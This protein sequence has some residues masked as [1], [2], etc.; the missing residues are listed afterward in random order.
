MKVRNNI[1]GVVFNMRDKLDSKKCE[2]INFRTKKIPRGQTY[3]RPK[4]IIKSIIELI[5]INGSRCRYV[6]LFEKS[7]AEYFKVNSAIAFPYARTAFYFL[8]KAYNFQPNS[9]VIIT[10]ITTDEILNVILLN[11]LKPVFVDIGYDTGNIKISEIEKNITTQTRA[12][13]VTH[14]NGIPSEM[15]SILKIKKKYDLVV[16][17]DAS[18]SIGAKY[19]NNYLGSFVD[20]GVF[21]TS[22]HKPLCTFTGG[23]V[24]TGDKRLS[25][26]LKNYAYNLD[27]GNI[28]SLIFSTIKELL[29][30]IFSNKFIFSYFTYNLIKI[31]NVL[32]PEVIDRLQHL[33]FSKPKRWE[34]MPKKFL[35]S[36]TSYQATIGIKAFKTFEE[37]T[38]KRSYLGYLL[39][40][41]LKKK[42][43]PGLVKIPF[44]SFCSFWRFPLWVDN[45]KK[46]RNYL[47]SEG[48]DTAVSG[49]ECYSRGL[50]FKE[51]N[52]NTPEAFRFIDDMVFLPIHSNM[53]KNEI[54]Y[55][56]CT[57]GKYYDDD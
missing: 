48:I 1:D 53:E 52:K 39:Y 57:V 38:I 42:M 12:L 18:Q 11:G 56:A 17:E 49:L 20:A 13:I 41:E 7:F 24:V 43:I 50:L 44:G 3:L 8:L 4:N 34:K 22:F 6:E 35:K 16:F 21:S 46:F 14:L 23:I 47:F 51:F 31:F 10:P 40:S 55:I 33:D 5:K 27:S 29:L 54:E 30:Y 19:K 9:E 45:P 37:D 26:Q 25:K 2:E 28:I 15:D 32:S 36:F